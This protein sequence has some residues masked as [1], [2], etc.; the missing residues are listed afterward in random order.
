M[1]ELISPA[2]P[3]S[4]ASAK[5]RSISRSDVNFWVDLLL[6]VVFLT[7]VW[8]SVILRFVFPPA[9]AAVGWTL[10]GLAYDDWVGVQFGVLSMLALVVLL[11]VMLHWSWVCGVVAKS[12]PRRRARTIRLDEGTQTLYGV[13]LLI[14]LVNVVGL[15][16]AAAA[17]MIRNSG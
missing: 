11:H 12:L 4:T 9:T 13:G 2:Q 8:V 15:A 5:T 14:S 17:L 7:L 3:Q 16:I 1:P 10:W 6:L